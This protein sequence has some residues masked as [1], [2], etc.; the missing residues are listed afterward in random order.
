[1]TRIEL[2]PTALRHT[3]LRRC[4][5][6]IVGLLKA[7]YGGRALQQGEYVQVFKNNLVLLGTQK[8]AGTASTNGTGVIVCRASRCWVVTCRHVLHEAGSGALFAIPKP[9]RTKSPRGGYSVLSLECPSVH[10]QDSLTHN[11]D[12]GV[13]AIRNLRRDHLEQIGIY[14]VE[15]PVGYRFEEP[16]EGLIVKGMGYPAEHAEK[17]LAFNDERP[18]PVK[19]AMGRVRNI[20]LHLLS[21]SGFVNNLREGYFVQTLDNQGLEKGASGGL[22]C[23]LDEPVGI[24]VGS[25][26]VTLENGSST[27][28]V[29]GFVFAKLQRVAEI[30]DTL[31]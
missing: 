26:D 18:L 4:T 12:I 13:C 31:L 7:E 23:A 6:I 22:V 1:M 10:P 20:P 9:K 14:P 28:Y 8:R 21:Q 11:F 16:Q 29:G 27:E 24:I 19:E 15:M 2:T 5:I 3:M 25:A 17:Y 30:L